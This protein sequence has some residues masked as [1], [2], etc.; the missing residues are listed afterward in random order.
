MTLLPAA[1]SDHK[2]PGAS[3]QETAAVDAA[4]DELLASVFG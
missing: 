4:I 1:N 3:K 2:F